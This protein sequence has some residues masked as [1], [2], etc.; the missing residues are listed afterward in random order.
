MSN[1]YFCKQHCGCLRLT[2]EFGIPLEYACANCEYKDVHN[3][4]NDKYEY[5][6]SV[7]LPIGNDNYLWHSDYTDAYKAE[8]VALEVG[9]VVAHN[10]RIS[11]KREKKSEI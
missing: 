2:A 3:Y 10:V 6:F 5:E 11:G 8:K 1:I 4:N 9:G 7:V